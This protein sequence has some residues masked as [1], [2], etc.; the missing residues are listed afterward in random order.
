MEKPVYE[1]IFD[2]LRAKGMTQEE[3]SK[4][5]G[6][7]ESTI[8]DWKKKKFNPGLDKIPVICQALGV[9]SAELLETENNSETQDFRYYLSEDEKELIDKYR[10]INDIDKEHIRAYTRFL[11]N[12]FVEK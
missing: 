11:L 7:P 6:I 12:M 2:I 10:L 9:S 3:L 8:S 1:K 4:A 5:T